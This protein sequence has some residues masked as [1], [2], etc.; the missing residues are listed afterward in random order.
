MI[1]LATLLRLLLYPLQNMQ[2][3][4]FLYVSAILRYDEVWQAG[5]VIHI[6][7]HN[8]VI[9]FQKYCIL[10]RLSKCGRRG[11][12]VENRAQLHYFVNLQL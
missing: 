7:I 5:I 11:K 1:A 3:L 12:R 8:V 4:S 2:N 6:H 9:V 10:F